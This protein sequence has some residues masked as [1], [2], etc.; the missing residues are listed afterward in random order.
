MKK[1]ILLV[2]SMVGFAFSQIATTEYYYLDIGSNLTSLLSQRNPAYLS[3]ETQPFAYA[4]SYQLNNAG[5][6]YRLPFTPESKTYQNI[7]VTAFQNMQN[8][9]T[10]AVRFAYRYEQ[11]KNKLWLHNA[12]NNLNIPFYFADSSIG[13]FTLNGIDW[14]IIFSYPLTQHI[15]IAVDVFYNVDEQFK[16]VFPKPNIKRNDLHL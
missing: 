13:D 7:S 9:I 12:E 5:G 11:R 4:F 3:P 16:S 10:F 2:I 1:L 15:R 6:N 8:E 14:N